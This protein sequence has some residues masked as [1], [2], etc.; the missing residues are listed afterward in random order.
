M[1]C[2]FLLLRFLGGY[3]GIEARREMKKTPVACTED[4]THMKTAEICVRLHR[5]G[6]WSIKL[7]FCCVSFL[8]WAKTHSTHQE[9]PF[10]PQRPNCCPLEKWHCNQNS[11]S[12]DFDPK[13]E[14]K[15]PREHL[16][17]NW[18]ISH[19]EG[20]GK[21][22]QDEPALGF[23]LDS[24]SWW[25]QIPSPRCQQRGPWINPSTLGLSPVSKG[26]MELFPKILRENNEWRGLGT[27][28]R[29]GTGMF[30]ITSPS[31]GKKWL[32][33]HFL[34]DLHVCFKC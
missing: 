16:K 27:I 3:E 26:G 12:P 5:E 30:R 1:N 6:V 15:G 4:V 29:S 22:S 18:W 33:W 10:I 13:K 23:P 25:P 21:T 7:G 17:L 28:N 2:S 32:F 19:E 34:Q 14:V 8:H 11:I 9:K 20:T 31:N 24:C